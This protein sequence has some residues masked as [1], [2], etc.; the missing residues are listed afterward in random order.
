MSRLPVLPLLCRLSVPRAAPLTPPSSSRAYLRSQQVV[1]A[2][3]PDG[4]TPLFL[5]R[6]FHVPNGQLFNSGGAGYMLNKASLR[7]LV[8]HLDGPE[9]QPHLRGFYEDV[10]VRVRSAEEAK[11]KTE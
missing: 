4:T 5:G 11:E 10:Q 6:R 7:L 3:G 9:C 1:D 8:S 2:A